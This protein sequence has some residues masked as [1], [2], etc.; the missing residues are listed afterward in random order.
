MWAGERIY[1]LS[2]RDEKKRFNLYSYDLRS[3]KTEKHTDFTEFDVKFP[4]LGDKAI[5][6]ENGG[7]I[8]RFDLASRK[9]VKVPIVVADDQVTG[10]GGWID[11]S[12]RV[13]NYEIAPDGSRALFGA[14]GEVFTVPAKQGRTLNLTRTSGV[15]ERA[16]KWSP[17]G[18]WIAWISDA[19]GEDE[20]YLAPRDGSGPPRG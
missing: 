15:H 6:F 9:A 13:S 2:D 14:H 7:Y 12:N 4:S 16:S 18:K 11:V 17:D 19:S 3:K 1:F 8:Y 20:I 10:R 5:V